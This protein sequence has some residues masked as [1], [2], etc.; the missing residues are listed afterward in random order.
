MPKSIDDNNNFIRKYIITSTNLHVVVPV[1]CRVKRYTRFVGKGRKRFRPHKE[2]MFLI[3]ITSR[4]D[5]AI[6]VCP[7]VPLS[8]CPYKR[9]DLGN[10]K[11][12]I[13]G[14]RHADS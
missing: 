4:V 9:C 11:S 14:T 10:Y 8:V 13:T 6:S 3:R 2:C 1:T 7:F 5:L 12:Y